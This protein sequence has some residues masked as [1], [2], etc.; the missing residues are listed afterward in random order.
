[1]TYG[2]LIVKMRKEANMTQ[3]EFAEYCFTSIK[4]LQNWEREGRKV[5]ENVLR[6][7]AY[8]LR[9]DQ[10]ISENTEKMIDKA[11]PEKKN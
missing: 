5:P 9:M 2:E 8:K 11:T 10:L 4:T 1:M 6:L 3:K 7:V